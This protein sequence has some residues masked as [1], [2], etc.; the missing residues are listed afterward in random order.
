[1]VG[2]TVVCRYNESRSAHIR[3]FQ[4]EN[5]QESQDRRARPRAK[6]RAGRRGSPVQLRSFVFFF[7]PP[8]FPLVSL[9]LLT[10]PPHSDNSLVFPPRF[11]F[12]HTNSAPS[13]SSF[14]YS[15]SLIVPFLPS[16][17]PFKFLPSLSL[18][19]SPRLSC[20]FRGIYTFCSSPP[21]FTLPS[22]SLSSFF[23]PPRLPKKA[24]FSQDLFTNA[25]LHTHAYI[26]LSH[27]RRH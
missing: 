12:N 18:S 8:H 23:Q 3:I 21:S 11:S 4:P 1:M 5:K 22:S 26:K 20:P 27:L 17:L 16:P 7:L 2:L 6:I 25:H 9:S 10:S 13:S 24:T 14:F 19:D 15:S